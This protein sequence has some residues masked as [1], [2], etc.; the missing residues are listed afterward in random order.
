M[1]QIQ[2]RWVAVFAASQLLALIVLPPAALTVITAQLAGAA[3]ISITRGVVISVCVGGWL[4]WLLAFAA[5]AAE[6]IAVCKGHFVR[7]CALGARVQRHFARKVM[8]LVVALS[9]ANDS[10]DVAP[11]SLDVRI[12]RLLNDNMTRLERSA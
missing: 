5:V 10:F 9:E 3:D 8:G 2:P 1:N 11:D 12:A 6:V 4:L 7:R